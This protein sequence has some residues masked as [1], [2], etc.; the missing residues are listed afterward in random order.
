MRNSETI[1]LAKRL[2]VF[3]MMAL[4]SQATLGG[5]M[6]S[7]E[8][9]KANK[10]AFEKASAGEWKDVFA[11]AGTD[12]WKKQWF[13]DGE[14]GKVT[15]GPEGMTLTA[16]P[17]FRNDAH[18]MVLWTK[19]EF[20]GDLKIEYDYTR[21]DEA[22]NCVTILYIQATGSGKGPYAKDISNW[23]ELRKVPSM[24]TYYNN[25][26]TYHISY[27][28]NPG[29]E[30][31]YIRGRRY[32]PNARGLRGTELKPDYYNPELFA[33][34]VKHH[35]TVIKR[36]RDLYMRIENPDQVQYCHFINEKLP[37][38]TEG[39]I[40]LRHMFTRSA[41]YA[42]FRVSTPA[43]AGK[44]GAQL[45][46]PQ[47][48]PQL[49][50]RI[51]ANRESFFAVD[52]GK[53]LVRGKIKKNWNNRGDFTRKYNQSIVMF[54]MRACELNEQL[55]EANAALRE[56]CHYHLERPQTFFEIH[57]FPG[58]CGHLSRLYRLY[59][60]RGTKAPNRLT[61]ETCAVLERT[62]WEWANQKSNIRDAEVEQSQTWWIT[63]SENHHAHHFTTC[64]A[65]TGTLRNVPTYQDKPLKDGHTPAEHYRAWTVYLKEYLRQRACRGMFIEI[66]S[67]SY[68]T[69][70]I[71]TMYACYDFSDDPVLK[72]RA[73]QLLELY[74]AQWAEQQINGVTGGAMTR[75]YP[76][77]TYGS[78]GFLPVAASYAVGIGEPKFHHEAFLPVA[79]TS[80]R[81]PDV[82]LEIAA[83]RGNQEPYE[84]L[85]RRPGLAVKGYHRPPNYRLRTDFGGILRYTY[86]T[87][88]FIMGSLITEA[89]PD[90]DWTAISSQNRWAGVVFKGH[91]NAR[92]F[93][94]PYGEKAMNGF[95]SL[96]SKG[97]TITQKLTPK[98]K[99]WRVFF[100]EAGLSEPT[101]IGTLVV[102]EA[103]TAYVGVRIVS[104]GSRW[105]AHKA[106]RW[107]ICSDANSPVIIEAA[108]KADY[109]SF[110]AFKEALKTR[111]FSFDKSVL[112]YQSLAG[113]TLT[114][115]ADKSRIGK[116]NDTPVDLAP[117]H[118]FHSPFVSSIWESGVVTIQYG[119]EN[120]ILNFN[121]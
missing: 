97:T 17:E 67:P 6:S 39:R 47:T 7:P 100:S 101:T 78:V 54:A 40:G 89:R 82:V 112:T 105:E 45:V 73:G 38:I 92:V 91:P 57:S 23:S 9:A 28:V 107:L 114:F 32:K 29:T 21:T 65:L 14:V 106:G 99:D 53:P 81:A 13:L 86:C 1:R 108:R 30:G 2:M 24:K 19:Q 111:P 56:M 121:E 60:P 20:E 110:H 25:M 41:R 74:W 71:N 66:D 11:D 59:G 42:N 36:D 3:T 72:R 70:V 80:W 16:G 87:P 120:R 27:A 79:T 109:K 77:K 85:Q 4:A 26:N 103:E 37:V 88:D 5:N 62:M 43:D 55:D 10:Q 69:T 94:I 116:I 46:Q 58:A 113:E 96:Q 22:P 98:V 115:Y 119:E 95:W 63:A 64:W 102:A 15:T 51:Q 35:I 118:V 61:K 8:Q 33:T 31:S 44:D 90:E 52:A 68:A 34:G 48:V 76:E 50:A 75:C 84:I 18:H 104:G 12:D 83:N 49:R 93:A 117:Q